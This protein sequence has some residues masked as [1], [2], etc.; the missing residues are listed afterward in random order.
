MDWPA[1][2]RSYRAALNRPL[3][4]EIANAVGAQQF[5]QYLFFAQWQRLREYAARRGVGHH[6]RHPDF[7]R[8]RQLQDVWTHPEIFQLQPTRSRPKPLRVAGVPP[9][10]DFSPLGQLWGNPLYDWPETLRADH[11]L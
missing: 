8:A 7:C 10:R 1:E 9:D 4:H 3:T 6:W 5:F 2:W 11:W